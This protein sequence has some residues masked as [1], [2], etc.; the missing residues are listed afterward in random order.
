MS[1][2]SFTRRAAFAPQM[3][4]TTSQVREGQVKDK[5]LILPCASEIQVFASLKKFLMYGLGLVSDIT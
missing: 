5:T 2:W 1:E 4:S 3:R